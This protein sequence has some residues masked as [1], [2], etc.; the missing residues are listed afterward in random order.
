VFPLSSRM[1]KRKEGEEQQKMFIQEQSQGAAVRFIRKRI[2]Q[3]WVD[4]ERGSRKHFAPLTSAPSAFSVRKWKRERLMWS[5]S[6]PAIH[7]SL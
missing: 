4:S 5:L 6:R 3:R 2:I 7:P 1:Q